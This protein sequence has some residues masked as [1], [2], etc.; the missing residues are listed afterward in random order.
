MPSRRR[1]TP[2]IVTSLVTRT[3]SGVPPGRQSRRASVICGKRRGI[4][5]P[6]QF[7]VV[8]LVARAQRVSRH[9]DRRSGAL[10]GDDPAGVG[11]VSRSS[12]PGPSPRTS[13]DPTLERAST[14]TAERSETISNRPWYGSEPPGGGPGRLRRGDTLGGGGGVARP[15]GSPRA[16]PA[17]VAPASFHAGQRRRRSRPRRCSGAGRRRA[18]RAPA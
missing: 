6:P 15:G 8:D 13:T 12:R 16:E 5:A 1:V 14:S 10:V 7:G 3:W 9:D 11:R 17:T 2:W 4:D 18:G